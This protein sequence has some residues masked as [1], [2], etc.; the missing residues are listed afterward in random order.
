[1]AYRSIKNLATS[2]SYHP[3]L[4]FHPYHIFEGSATAIQSNNVYNVFGVAH[5]E[6]FHNYLVDHPSMADYSLPLRAWIQLCDEHSTP[7]HMD[8]LSAAISWSLLGDYT[9]DRW[10]ACPTV[11]FASLIEF[12][13]KTGVPKNDL[14]IATLFEQWSAALNAPPIQDAIANAT[15]AN[16]RHLLRLEATID[17]NADNPF[18][19]LLRA[20][21]CFAAAQEAMAKKFIANP[22]NYVR[23][24]EY[25]EHAADWIS[26]PIR[27]DF[28]FEPIVGERADLAGTFNI[29]VAE[30]LSD[31]R[32]AVRR[33]LLSGPTPGQHFFED[34]LA[35]STHDLMAFSDFF[36]AE[37][38]RDEVDFDVVRRVSE[39]M[40]M[41]TMEILE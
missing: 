38:C 12:L 11:R 39:N 9:I 25:A 24:F 35:A 2:P 16:A 28:P 36:F 8:L 31:G 30:E 6:V 7:G 40:G 1:M 14:P 3:N 15:K 5:Q 41:T 23:P 10:D 4:A 17:R 32:L 33:A 22:D 19:L 34:D 13:R 21:R 20:F 18:L 27:L 37:F 26:A 29:R